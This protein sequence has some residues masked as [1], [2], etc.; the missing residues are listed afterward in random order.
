MHR[1]KRNHEGHESPGGLAA[2]SKEVFV[3]FAI[4][5]FSWFALS[6]FETR[7]HAQESV[8]VLTP[9][10]HDE[11]LAQ[12]GGPPVHYAISIPPDYRRGTA[13]P[14][15]LALH[16]GGD[17]H[18]AGRA[19]LDI[20]VSPALADLGAIIVAP[21]SLASGWSTAQNESAVNALLAG[22]EKAYDI[23][24][25][26]VIV[27]GFSMGGA[28]TWYWA[29]KYPDRFS[30]AIPVSGRPTS[31]TWRVPVFAVH[32]RDD[33]VVPIGPAEERIAELKKQGVNA[34]IVVVSGIAHFETY[35]FVSALRQAVPWIQ[36]IWSKK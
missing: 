34:Q 20:L 11:V 25:K 16:F 27:T 13:V 6:V 10:V 23:D 31:G 29:G 8:P 12:K 18:G 26:K 2:R 19:M 15:V 21:D 14:L 3:I 35:K 22:V 24:R 9:G 4:F 7:I 28:G 36:Q 32:S 1:S 33:R 30:A 17:P 5:V